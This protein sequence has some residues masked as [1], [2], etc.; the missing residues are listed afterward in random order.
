MTSHE[1]GKPETSRESGK[2]VIF[3]ESARPATYSA[4][5]KGMLYSADERKKMYHANVEKMKSSADAK[6]SRSHTCKICYKSFKHAR[7]HDRHMKYSHKDGKSACYICGRLYSGR[8]LQDH[9]QA[10]KRKG[11]FQCKVCFQEF[12]YRMQLKRHTC[13]C[14]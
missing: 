14:R 4:N 9:I 13:K 7:S 10:H 2:P 12:K 8:Y 5:E 1:S 11:A 3:Q 6:R